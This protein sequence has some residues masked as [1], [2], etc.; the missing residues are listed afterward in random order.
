MRS[1]SDQN[2]YRALVCL[3]VELKEGIQV[4]RS[5]EHSRKR[6]WRR[7]QLQHYF[8]KN[9]FKAAKKVIMHQ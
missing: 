1:C 4:L 2:K 8:F 9:P 6:R 3:M 5:P 7:K